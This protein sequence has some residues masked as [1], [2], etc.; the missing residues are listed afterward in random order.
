MQPGGQS[1]PPVKED[2]HERRCSEEELRSQAVVPQ[3]GRVS[4]RRLPSA[5]GRQ[6][7]A[8]QD[9]Q[10]G[11][12]TVAGDTSTVVCVYVLFFTMRLFLFLCATDAQR[13]SSWFQA[14]LV[15]VRGVLVVMA[16]S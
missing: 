4:C 10:A 8:T 12:G 1:N 14:L 9:K 3:P 2:A 6:Q 7:R 13:F 11:L 16:V 15:I 5:C